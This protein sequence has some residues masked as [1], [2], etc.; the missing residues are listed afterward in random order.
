MEGV[1]TPLRCHSDGVP[2]PKAAWQVSQYHLPNDSHRYDWTSK[3][4]SPLPLS[5]FLVPTI[6]SVF[7]RCVIDDNTTV[8]ILSPTSK[9]DSAKYECLAKSPAG[10]SVAATEV[11]VESKAQYSDGKQISQHLCHTSNFY[12]FHKRILVS[13]LLVFRF[14]FKYRQ[15]DAIIHM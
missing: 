15:C 7:V 3:Q 13:S 10:W 14:Q 6:V 11:L 12:C 8:Y 1:A 2:E 9:L 4:L 5:R